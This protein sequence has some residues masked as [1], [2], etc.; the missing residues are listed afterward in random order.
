MILIESM[1]GKV[2]THSDTYFALRNGVQY[3]GTRCNQ[4][5]TPFSEAELKNQTQFK[6]AHTAAVARLADASQHATDLAAFKKQ[7]KYKTLLGY[8][9]AEEYKK[10]TD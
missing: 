3:T 7:Q 5:T 2:C 8:L 4:R 1:R 6:S 10:I 9:I